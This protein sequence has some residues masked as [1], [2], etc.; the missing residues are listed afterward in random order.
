MFIFYTMFARGVYMTTNLW[1]P[2]MAFEQRLR[3]KCLRSGHTD[4]NANIF[5][6]TVFKKLIKILHFNYNRCFLS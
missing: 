2:G 3:S 4:S 1:I 6:M 5:Y